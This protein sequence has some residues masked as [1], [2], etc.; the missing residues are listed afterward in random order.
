MAAGER[1]GDATGPAQV[2]LSAQMRWEPGPEGVF[3]SLNR[4]EGEKPGTHSQRGTTVCPV[5]KRHL[6]PRILGSE[7]WV[8][9]FS[10]CRFQ[11]PWLELRT[12]QSMKTVVRPQAQMRTRSWL[13]VLTVMRRGVGFMM[14]KT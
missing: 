1:V 6:P 7:T 11:M 10:G 8:R 2:G 4:C 13:G 12:R 9:V 5:D 3:R 14:N